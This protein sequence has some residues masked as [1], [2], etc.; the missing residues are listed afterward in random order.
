MYARRAE[1]R[2]EAAGLGASPASSIVD[3]V[4][5]LASPRVV[6][7]MIPAGQAVDAKTIADSWDEM[8]FTNDPIATSLKKSADDAEAVGL[9]DPVDLT[10]IYD[11][12]LLN[13]VL[14]PASVSGS[15]DGGPTTTATGSP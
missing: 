5:H 3:L 10:G 7:L 4:G 9:L 8:T 14:S 2:A 6:W 11:L 1:V 12:K 13:E 15:M